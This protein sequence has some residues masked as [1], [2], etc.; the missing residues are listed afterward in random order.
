KW[1][2]STLVLMPLFGVHYTVLLWMSG[3][4]GTNET[5]EVVWLFCDQFF[6]SFQGFFVAVLYCLVNGEVRAEL[7]R[8]WKTFKE[9]FSISR[10]RQDSKT[11]WSRFTISTRTT[12]GRNSMQSV[13]TMTLVDRKDSSLSPSPYLSRQTGSTIAPPTLPL[14]EESTCNSSNGD[15]EKASPVACML[16]PMTCIVSFQASEY[17]PAFKVNHSKFVKTQHKYKEPSTEEEA[18]KLI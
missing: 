5:V 10:Q 13:N 3:A 1:G 8:R 11:F 6:A 9:R 17:V 14:T 7:K 18:D 15:E 16:E 12:T 4:M 2:K